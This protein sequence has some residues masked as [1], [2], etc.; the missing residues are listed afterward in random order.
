MKD[1]VYGY[2]LELALCGADAP[3][4]V[5]VRMFEAMAQLML[6]LLVM[7]VTFCTVG[8]P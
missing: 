4:A 6:T 2:R 3:L 8:V 5:Q 7:L 1:P